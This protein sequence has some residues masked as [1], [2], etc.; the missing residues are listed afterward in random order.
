MFDTKTIDQMIREKAQRE[1]RQQ[2]RDAFKPVREIITSGQGF[3]VAKLFTSTDRR[4][5]VEISFHSQNWAALEE[6]VYDQN[7]VAREQYAIEAFVKEVSSLR[8]EL[9]A[10][11]PVD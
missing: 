8:E 5:P 11:P 4:E 6:A 9:N 10:L 2:I 7:V 3:P 1:L